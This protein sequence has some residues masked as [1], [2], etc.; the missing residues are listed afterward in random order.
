MPRA[1]SARQR[2]ASRSAKPGLGP[3]LA[4]KILAEVNEAEI[5]AMSCDVINI[6]SPTGE[7]LGMAVYMRRVFEEMGLEVSWQE[8]EDGR[9]NVVGRLPG[10]GNGK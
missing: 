7:E 5:V 6:P 4:E 9:A 3:K 2:K 10:S 1:V 8:V